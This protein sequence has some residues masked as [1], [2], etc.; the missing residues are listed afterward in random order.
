MIESLF[1]FLSEMILH[2]HRHIAFI[3][4]KKK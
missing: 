4:I 1:K 3:K 2:P